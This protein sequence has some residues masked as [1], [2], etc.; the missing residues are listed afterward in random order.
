M[1]VYFCMLT[2]FTPMRP[3]SNFELKIKTIACTRPRI[4]PRIMAVDAVRMVL[5]PFFALFPLLDFVSEASFTT[6]LI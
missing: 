5:F 1:S 3:R 6:K 2:G 4:K